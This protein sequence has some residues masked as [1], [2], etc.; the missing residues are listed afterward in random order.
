MFYGDSYTPHRSWEVAEP[1]DHPRVGK[2]DLVA[3]LDKHCHLELADITHMC[4]AR[5]PKPRYTK[6]LR[7]PIEL[8]RTV[9]I[10]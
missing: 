9:V 10:D 6:V 5:H 8:P 3:F 4:L 7:L 2:H 1:A